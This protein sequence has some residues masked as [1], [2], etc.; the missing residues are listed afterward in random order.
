MGV[1]LLVVP[2][3][4]MAL[5]AAL[6]VQAVTVVTCK[7]TDGNQYFA[8]RCPPEAAKLGEKRVPVGPRRDSAQALSDV[9]KS[10]PVVL[11]SVADCDACDLVRHQLTTRGIPFTERDVSD[12]AEHQ[13][14]LKDVANGG[15]TVPT[16]SI[17][18]KAFTG[19][20]RAA[21]EMGLNEAGYPARADAPAPT[22]DAAATN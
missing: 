10:H 15:T 12:S 1:R 5:A 21:L 17:G 4:A 7:D 20:S 19:Y 8:D 11:Y 9:A 22:T 3:V 16:V 6:P 14:A 2:V 18:T 13:T